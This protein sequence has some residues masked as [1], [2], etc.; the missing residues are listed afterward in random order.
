MIILLAV[1]PACQ[2]NHGFIESTILPDWLSGLKI[3]TYGLMMACGFISANY[4]LQKEFFRLNI[5]VKLADSIIIALVVGGLLGAKIFYVW[6]TSSR[7]S[8]W[9]GFKDQMF[10]LGGLTWYGGMVVAT[11]F[12][13]ILLYRKKMSFMRMA[14]ISTPALALGYMFG[15]LGCLL[16]GDGCYGIACTYN[17]PA[18]FAMAFPNGHAHWSDIT[19]MYNNPDV[20]V[21][22]TPLYEAFISLLLFSYFYSK[23]KNEWPFGTKV[24]TFLILH[25]LQRFF[26]EFIRLNPKD[27]LGVTQAQFVSIVLILIS[28]VYLILKRKEIQVYLKEGQYGNT[29]NK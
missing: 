29:P 28:V 22:N 9:Q 24:V 5:P 12:A 16:S 18:P 25:S 19:Q 14:D 20:V 11:L 3:S 10:S 27:V 6:E 13:A 23:R 17:W 2:Y 7:W 26:I 21:Y 8:G 4:L 1:V 15:R